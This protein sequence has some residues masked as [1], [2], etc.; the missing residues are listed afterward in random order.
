MLRRFARRG[1]V[2][3]GLLARSA[4][5]EQRL[6]HGMHGARSLC[7]QGLPELLVAGGRI[8]EH[9]RQAQR[10]GLLADRAAQTGRFDAE[11]QEHRVGQL[12]LAG[13]VRGGEVEPVQHPQRLGQL[14]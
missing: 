2:D 14:G 7:L 11:L 8:V 1:A 3:G 5:L 6:Q 12:V 10:T 13:G 4:D 9:E